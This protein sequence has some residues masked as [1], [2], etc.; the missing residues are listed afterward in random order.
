[1]H[2]FIYIYIY[3]HIMFSAYL[4]WRRRDGMDG[5][6][7]LRRK[8]GRALTH[9]YIYIHIYL[10]IYLSIYRY[11][12]ISLSMYIYIY[13]HIYI[14]TE[15]CMRA[16]EGV[17]RGTAERAGRAESEGGDHA[18]WGRL[19][20]CGERQ[21]LLMGYII[22]CLFILLASRLACRPGPRLR[23]LGSWVPRPPGNH[24]FKNFTN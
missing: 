16:S 14:C 12:S 22:S 3:I 15:G 9:I 23:R 13:I 11:I 21:G 2:T 19:N 7:G 17:Q 4:T 10:S 20:G 5:E 1:M 24:T 18:R 8:S 6:A